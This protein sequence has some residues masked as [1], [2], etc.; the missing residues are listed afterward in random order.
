MCFQ[1]KRGST[2]KRLIA[3]ERERE[4]GGKGVKASLYTDRRLAAAYVT[5]KFLTFSTVTPVALAILSFKFVLSASVGMALAVRAK[6]TPT[7]TVLPV[8]GLKVGMLVGKKDIVGDIL[9]RK[10]GEEVGTQV[11]TKVGM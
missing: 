6:S 7:E 8:V 11:G 9:G 2:Q 4:G 5:A 10:V 3:R 1:S